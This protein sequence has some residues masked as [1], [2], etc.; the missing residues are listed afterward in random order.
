MSLSCSN[1]A[2]SRKYEYGGLETEEPRFRNTGIDH[3]SVEVLFLYRAI[4]MIIRCQR[5]VDVSIDRFQGMWYSFICNKMH[6][7]Y[8]TNLKGNSGN[9]I[10]IRLPFHRAHRHS[11]WEYS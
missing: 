7:S 4:S 3:G 5:D 1:K 9:F 8:S 11:T 10:T 6:T 2:S